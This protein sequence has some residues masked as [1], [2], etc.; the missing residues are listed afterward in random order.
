MILNV[1]TIV[2]MHMRVVGQGRYNASAGTS[3]NSF[4]GVKDVLML[5]WAL[6]HPFAVLLLFVFLFL[7]ILWCAQVCVCVCVCVC[8]SVCYNSQNSRC[9]ATVAL[10]EQLPFKSSR[11]RLSISV[12][13]ASNPPRVPIVFL[14]PARN[15][16]MPCRGPVECRSWSA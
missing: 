10:I 2:P 5:S 14:Y 1:E 8:V 6:Q 12:M 15:M 7:L 9:R 16:V 11:Q 3:G 13:Q 4:C